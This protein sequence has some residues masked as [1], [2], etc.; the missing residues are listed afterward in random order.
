MLVFQINLYEDEPT[1]TRSQ[2]LFLNLR[3]E[4]WLRIKTG[5]K[6]EEKIKEKNSKHK[7]S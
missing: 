2:E 3:S 7:G 1:Y 6:V 4:G 5:E